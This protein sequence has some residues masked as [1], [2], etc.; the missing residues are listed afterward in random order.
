MVAI[1]KVGDD[2]SRNAARNNDSSG[3]G[4]SRS[5]VSDEGGTGRG[6]IKTKEKTVPVSSNDRS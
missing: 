6:D 5:K 2:E 3:A 4:C 1:Q